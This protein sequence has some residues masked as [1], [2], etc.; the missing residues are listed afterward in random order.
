MFN[1]HVEN[2]HLQKYQ[3]NIS[4]TF[5]FLPFLLCLLNFIIF[6][7]KKFKGKRGVCKPRITPIS[8]SLDP[9]MHYTCIYIVP[10]TREPL[11]GL[12]T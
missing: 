12:P 10:A 6:S 5:L 9:P 1:I 4:A 7:L 2:V 11:L 8:P 3:T